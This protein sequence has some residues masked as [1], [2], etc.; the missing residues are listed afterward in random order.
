MPWTLGHACLAE[1]DLHGAEPAFARGVQV[2]LAGGNLMNIALA[3]TEM[4][5]VR[6][7][8][9]RLGAALEYYLDILRRAE[10]QGARQSYVLS[11]VELWV[12]DI[13]ME[14]YDLPEARR[15]VE[16]ADA[17]VRSADQPNDQ[18]AAHLTPARVSCGLKAKRRPPRQGASVRR[19]A[20]SKL[21][22]C[23]LC[24]AGPLTVSGCGCD[25]RRVATWPRP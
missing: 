22:P 13:Y 17:H 2:S 7:I 21:P 20:A 16:L 24:S 14:R 23:H 15:W 12:G 5:R 25:W 6:K 4:A 10:K 9:G 11:G 8:Q 1:G 18:A 3:L 19:S